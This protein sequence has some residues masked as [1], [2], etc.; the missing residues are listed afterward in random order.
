M[1]KT[2]LIVDDF[3]NTRWVIEFTIKNLGIEILSA[4]NG[5]EALKYFEDAT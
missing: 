5:E 2:V 3:E 1:K 4:S